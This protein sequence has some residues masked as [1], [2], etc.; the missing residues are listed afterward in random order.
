MLPFRGIVGRREYEGCH[1]RGRQDA[2]HDPQRHRDRDLVEVGDQHLHAHEREDEAEPDLEVPEESHDPGQ[3]EEQGA[4]AEDGE[5]VGRVH[6][7]WVL[8]DG[9]DGGHR[10]HGEHDVGRLNN[11]QNRNE[12]GPH[13]FS[14]FR[15][16]KNF[17][18]SYPVSIGMRRVKKRRTGFF[19]GSTSTSPARR[20]LTPVKTR[21]APK[22]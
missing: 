4:E 22:R 13:Q 9:E 10:V 15:R 12:S 20:S 7:E 8:G 11:D 17:C 16:T 6:D 14:P 5:D 21:K 3:Q 1:D 18:A 19:C 2:R